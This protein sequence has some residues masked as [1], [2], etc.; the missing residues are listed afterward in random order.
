MITDHIARKLNRNISSLTYKLY[1]L[2]S[3]SDLNL[4]F[5]GTAGIPTGGKIPL[6]RL[7]KYLD[8]IIN[9]NILVF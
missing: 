6:N 2:G 8:R 5:K 9:L 7:E 4:S 1:H 3:N